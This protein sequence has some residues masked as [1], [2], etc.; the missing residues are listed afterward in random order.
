MVQ[1]N[2]YNERRKKIVPY[3]KTHMI[4]IIMRRLHYAQWS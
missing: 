1:T 3:V 2:G 4:F